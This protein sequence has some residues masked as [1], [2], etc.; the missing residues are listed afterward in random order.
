MSASWSIRSSKARGCIPEQ[1]CAELQSPCDQ[2]RP[3]HPGV[4]AYLVQSNAPGVCSHQNLF[5]GV[6]Y[7]LIGEAQRPVIA[8]LC[9][10]VTFRYAAAVSAAAP[11][12]ARDCSMRR[13]SAQLPTRDHWQKARVILIALPRWVYLRPS[14]PHCGL[15]LRSLIRALEK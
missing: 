8:R 4:G 6:G 12:D 13:R 9:R 11:S 1:Q 14:P 3:M 2:R 5:R 15:R 7:H 10:L